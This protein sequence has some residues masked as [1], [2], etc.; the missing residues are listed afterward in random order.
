MNKTELIEIISEE[1]GI[2]KQEARKVVESFIYNVTS[3]LRTKDGKVVLQGFGTFSVI[4]R[5][6]RQG[7]N[8]STGIPIK[9]PAKKAAKFKA[10]QNLILGSGSRRHKTKPHKGTGDGGPRKTN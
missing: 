1:A 9:I 10:S 3:T 5:A 7:V 8:P 6:A 2:T 4:Q